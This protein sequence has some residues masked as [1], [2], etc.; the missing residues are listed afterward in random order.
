[1][2]ETLNDYFVIGNG[3]NV[4]TMKNETL[5]QQTN[6]HCYDFQRIVDS[7][8]TKQIKGK[9]I[10]DKIAKAVETACFDCRNLHA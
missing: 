4:R 10:D 5:E 8:N 6:V 2:N 1:M 9:N 3:T 7:A